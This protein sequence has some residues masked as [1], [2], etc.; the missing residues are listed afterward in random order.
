VG[1]TSACLLASGRAYC[2]GSNLHGQLGS[3]GGSSDI[4][5]PVD[6]SG[7]LKDARLVRIAVGAAHACALDTRGSAYCWGLNSDGQLGVAGTDRS[8]RPVRVDQQGALAGRTLEVIGAAGSTTCSL[9]SRGALFC[10]GINDD[11]QFGNGT[12]KG[13]AAPVRG[14]STGDLDGRTLTR[15]ALGDTHTCGIDAERDT[16]CW[17]ANDH[18][19][20]GTGR[21]G[22][23]PDPRRVVP[24]E[25]LP[26]GSAQGILLGARSTCA[27]TTSGDAAC[28]GANDH[29][30]LGDGQ[31]SDS[32]VPQ[33]VLYPEPSTETSRIESGGDTACAISQSDDPERRVL[34]CWGANDVGQVGDGRTEDAPTPTPVST[35]SGL[36]APWLVRI[37]GRSGCALTEAQEAWCWGSNADGLLGS[38]GSVR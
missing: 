3:I 12:R 2:W 35:S 8:D 21:T 31:E 1:P 4:P 34:Y 10:W 9:D 6:T 30:Q 16:Y 27:R 36:A 7:A 23:S 13:G 24:T 15:F 33:R 25:A 28:W 37:G 17:G 26:R 18:G 38:G 32:S 5:R 11:G 14:A 19:Q 20:L 22:S 29:G